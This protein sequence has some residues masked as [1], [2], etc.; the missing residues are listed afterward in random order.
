MPELQE[1][2]KELAAQA[3]LPMPKIAISPS[4]EPNALFLE[5]LER[6]LHSL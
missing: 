5:G 6:V 1:M 3:H 2:V 4:K